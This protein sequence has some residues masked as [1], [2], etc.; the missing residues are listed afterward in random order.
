MS[1]CYFQVL[2]VEEISGNLKTIA[3]TVISLTM[4]VTYFSVLYNIVKLQT[5]NSLHS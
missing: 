4:L 2:T 3:Y 5:C 1:N